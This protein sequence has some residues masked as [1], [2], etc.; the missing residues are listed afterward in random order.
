MSLLN[1]LEPD[2]ARLL[3]HHQVTVSEPREHMVQCSGVAI[4]PKFS[5]PC[6]NLLFRSRNATPP[7]VEW[8]IYADD[9]LQYLGHNLNVSRLFQGRHLR[10]WQLLTPPEPASGKLSQVIR[11]TLAWLLR[12]L[13]IAP[14]PVAAPGPNPATCSAQLARGSCNSKRPPIRPRAPCSESLRDSR[15]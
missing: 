5:K 11:P 8:E 1:Q 4:G 12:P 3:A 10:R 6:T 2:L 7:G 13:L 9:D 15:S 14:S